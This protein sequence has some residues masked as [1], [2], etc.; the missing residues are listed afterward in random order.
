VK[1]GRWILLALL[2]GGAGFYGWKRYAGQARL[3]FVPVA[4]TPEVMVPEGVRIK[5]EVLNATN[6]RGLARKATMFL[7]DRGFDVVAVGTAP[8][9]LSSTLVLDRSEH[10]GWAKLVASAFGSRMEQRPD[11]SRYLDVTVLV[12]SDWHPPALP[13]YP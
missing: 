13:F 12:G 3:P 10:P 11:S 9:Q 1:I 5:V 7:R 4:A 6:V 8:E 2:L